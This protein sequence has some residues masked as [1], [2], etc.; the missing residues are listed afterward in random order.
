[1]AQELLT[2]RPAQLPTKQQAI[3][4]IDRAQNVGEIKEIMDIWEAARAYAQQ[5][6]DKYAKADAEEVKREAQ[7]KIGLMMQAELRPHGGINQYNKEESPP[8]SSSRVT[9]ATLLDLGLSAHTQQKCREEARI[10][11]ERWKEHIE[12]IR[13]KIL[14]PTK[15]EVVPIKQP[16]TE[17]VWS[18]RLNE[19]QREFNSDTATLLTTTGRLI[20]HSRNKPPGLSA[21][22]L[23][24]FFRAYKKIGEI[25]LKLKEFLGE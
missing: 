7:R 22:I 18:T 2:F 23:D 20:S 10:P 24:D 1:M 3:S 21:P 16:T 9:T 13:E 19:L 14:S 4:A 5:K 12:A 11:Q 6:N 25:H 15:K 8:D 17:E